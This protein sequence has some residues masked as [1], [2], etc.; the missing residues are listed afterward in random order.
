LSLRALHSHHLTL[1]SL[2]ANHSSQVRCGMA[3][4][5]VLL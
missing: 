3:A 5:C 1:S 2:R 4:A